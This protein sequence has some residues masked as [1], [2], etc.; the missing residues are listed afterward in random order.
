M[1]RKLL[2]FLRGRSDAPG[3]A[4]PAQPAEH[5]PG[6]PVAPPTTPYPPAI[7]VDLQSAQEGRVE[8]EPED[9]AE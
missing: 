2:D 4:P 6:V 7:D 1:L 8:R 3:A 5:G 9:R